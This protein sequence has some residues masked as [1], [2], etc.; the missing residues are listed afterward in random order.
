M[1]KHA[2]VGRS[3]IGLEATVQLSDLRPIQVQGLN[4]CISDTSAKFGLL[5]SG[6]HG[7][8]GWLRCESRHAVDCDV[9]NVRSC[10][11]GS[12]HASGGNACS[13]MRMYMDNEIR[14]FLSDRANKSKSDP[15]SVRI[16]VPGYSLY[17]FADAGLSRPAIS[18]IP[19]MWIPSLTS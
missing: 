6:A 1:C 10:S 16:T 13:I 3:D 5:Q 11:S 14:I 12:Q 18:L 17:N 8:H 2:G 9:D 19:R 7:T 4:I 15:L